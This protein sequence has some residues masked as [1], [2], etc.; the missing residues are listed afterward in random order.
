LLAE[1][2]LTAKTRQTET[3]VVEERVVALVARATPAVPRAP[4]V[5]REERGATAGMA[6]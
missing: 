4:M 1:L 2:A 3:A 5:A 6:A